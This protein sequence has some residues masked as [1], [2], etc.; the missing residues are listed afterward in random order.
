MSALQLARE[1]GQ[2]PALGEELPLALLDP[3]RQLL[4]NGL[5][6]CSLDRVSVYHVSLYRLSIGQLQTL[7]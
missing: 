2:G 3:R 1:L 6:S 4:S 7:V 5:I